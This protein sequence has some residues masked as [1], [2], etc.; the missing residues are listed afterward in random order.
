MPLNILYHHRTRSRDG[1]SV[2]IDEMIGALREAGHSVELVEPRRVDALQTS[3][4]KSVLPKFVYELLEF[5]YSGIEF[6]KLARAI[7]RNRPDAIYERANIYM[8]S[9][10]VAARTFS[11]PLLLEVNAPLAEEREK[12]GGIAIRWLACWTE[13]AAWRGAD[14]VLPVTNVLAGYIEHAGVARD[15]IVVT[16]NGVDLNQFGAQTKGD[17]AKLP[18]TSTG[19]PILGFVGYIRD[20]HGLPQIVNL[21]ATDPMLSSTRL[22]VVGDGPGRAAL[23]NRAKELGVSDR[24]HVTGI[25]ARDRVASYIRTFDIALQPEVTA[26]A[27]PLKLFEYMAEGCAIIAP[28]AE[29]IREVLS[30]EVDGILFE[31]ENSAALAAAVR[32]LAGDKKLCEQLGAAAA[33]N[34]TTNNIT[35]KRN[36]ERVVSIIRRLREPRA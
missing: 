13:K 31:P 14:C 9:G 11:L 16:S 30:N 20:W 32:R 2:H 35:W 5:G 36:A 28:D 15:R 29:N 22:V 8:L 7:L 25:V 3:R 6:L 24:I 19:G 10:V 21:L 12:F 18:F 4:G 1:Q 26:Y 17:V 27:S 23:E 34:I 33:A